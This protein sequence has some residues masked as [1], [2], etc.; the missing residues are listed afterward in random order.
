MLVG[1]FN[2]LLLTLN[3]ACESN[4]HK[5]NSSRGEGLKDN[6]NIKNNGPNRNAN[7]NAYNVVG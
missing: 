1:V 7:P 3:I 4:G 2:A 5:L 6:P